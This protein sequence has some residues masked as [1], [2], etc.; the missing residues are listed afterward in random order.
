[1][2]RGLVPLAA[3]GALAVPGI[4]QAAERGIEPVSPADSQG[5]ELATPSWSGVAWGSL[6]G[7]HAIYLDETFPLDFKLS[8]RTADGWRVTRIDGGINNGTVVFR[9]VSPDMST[10]V[11][12]DGSP[13]D[14]TPG[15]TEGLLT[16][17]DGHTT[18]IIT[19]DS[20]LDRPQRPFYLAGSAD[21]SRLVLRVP[22][23]TVPGLESNTG[24]F[25]WS[26]AGGFEPIDV[27]MSRYAGADCADDPSTDFSREDLSTIGLADNGMMGVSADGST[28]VV[29]TPA[30]A[31][32]SPATPVP[33]HLVLWHD[34]TS[35]D[36]TTPVS[37]GAD[38][39]ATYIGMSP[40][41]SRVFFTTD[42]KLQASDTNGAT[43]LYVSDHGQLTRIT[44]G[45]VTAD[46]TQVSP[47]GS[48]VWFEADQPLGGAGQPGK[49]NIFLWDDGALHLVGT[50]KI[51]PRLRPGDGGSAF[52]SMLT[53]DG[54]Y[55]AYGD[56]FDPVAG[57]NTSVEIR[58]VSRDGTVVCATCA[59]PGGVEAPV[60]P[61]LPIYAFGVSIGSD[62]GG[63]FRRHRVREPFISDDGQTV[64]FQT[65][66]ALDPRDT[67][68]ITD[69]YAWEDGKRV[70]LSSGT[71]PTPGVSRGMSLDGS[72]IFFTQGGALS[73]DSTDPYQK[74]W[75]SRIGG[76]FPVARTPDPCATACQ[77]PLTAPPAPPVIATVSF[78][79]PGNLV[80]PAEAAPVSSKPKVSKPSGTVRGTSALV[81][82]KVPGGGVIRVSGAR[83]GTA[84]RTVLKA[85][86]YSVRVALT[87]AWQ[88]SLARH[89]SITAA[90][91]VQFTP[92]DGRAASASV[93]LKFAKATKKATSKK[94]AR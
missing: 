79:G 29:A 85:G 75:A 61:P 76:G 3:A 65:T 53:T 5:T 44:D 82:A 8:T 90:L 1:M 12:E 6:D 37:G 33:S 46:Q 50:Y 19:W 74:L 89:S 66:G 59:P 54:S 23:G 91:K 31:V 49:P 71:E 56:S 18:K 48:T 92:V 4:A 77:G 83:V 70:L 55:L 47:D 81:R 30:C 88:R 14:P 52:A 93:Q 16:E 9:D 78:A 10:V 67:N 24:L 58:R 2:I 35:T 94:A 42:A 7:N 22:T 32:G 40:D 34:G 43:D 62:S 17:H 13:Y 69:T 39:T 21:R 57:T 27:D 60:T 20:G 80:P 26:V 51:A 36:I 72:T 38:G 84:K 64:V 73:P 15:Y 11:W 28:V 68:G 41:G 25:R 86:T 45:V 87:K 63:S